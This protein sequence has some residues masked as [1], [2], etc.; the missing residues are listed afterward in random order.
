MSF[1]LQYI[2]EG[3][4]NIDNFLA[5][6]GGETGFIYYFSYSIG[7]GLPANLRLK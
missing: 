4:T 6:F 3:L 2:A 7:F 5:H 1:H